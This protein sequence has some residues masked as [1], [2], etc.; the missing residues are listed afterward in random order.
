MEDPRALASTARNRG[1]GRET[2]ENTSSSLK[3]KKESIQMHPLLEV[4]L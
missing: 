4:C 1:I 3:R 2:V